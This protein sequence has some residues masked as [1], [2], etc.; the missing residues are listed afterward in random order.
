[1]TDKEENDDTKTMVD[2]AHELFDDKVERFDKILALSIER[3]ILDDFIEG[4]MRLRDSGFDFDDAANTAA[5]ELNLDPD[6]EE[7]EV[8][9]EKD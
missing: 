2:K 7:L 3:E 5:E 9:E 1:M 4:Y 8:E 6:E